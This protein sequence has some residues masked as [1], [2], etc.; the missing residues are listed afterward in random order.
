MTTSARLRRHSSRRTE[1]GVLSFCLLTMMGDAVPEQQPEHRERPAVDERRDQPRHRRVHGGTIAGVAAEHR[2]SAEEVVR[3]GQRDEEQHEASRQVGGEGA[4]GHGGGLGRPGRHA[5][6]Q[7]RAG[8]GRTSARSRPPRDFRPRLSPENRPMGTA[9]SVGAATIGGW[10]T[11]SST[12]GR[13][14]GVG[15]T[16][17]CR[18]RTRRWSW[19]RGTRP[20]PS[21]RSRLRRRPRPRWPMPSGVWGPDC[22]RP[23][24]GSSWPAT[25]GACATIRSTSSVRRT[26]SAGSATRSA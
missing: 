20:S 6:S 5:S 4:G 11:T 3:V 17:G 23:T 8:G 2:R 16:S 22:R 19:R 25:A 14:C 9:M 15:R 26:R 1:R 7:G 18:A 12:G 21:W 10:T 13:S 24:G